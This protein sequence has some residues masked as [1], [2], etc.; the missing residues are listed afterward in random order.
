LCA[1]RGELG[2]IAAPELATHETLAAV[3]ERELRSS[4]AA[5]GIS[6]LHFLDLPDA[7]VDWAA[8]DAGTARALVGFIRQLKPRAIITFGPDGL[9]GHFDHVAIGSLTTEARTVAA[10]PF[11]FPDQGASFAGCRLFYPVISGAAVASL[12]DGA[13]R[14]G[15]PSSLWTLGPEHFAVSP[16][17]ITASVDVSTVLERKLAALHCHRTQLEADNVLLYL[18]AELARSFF[19]TEHFRCADGLPGGPL[20]SFGVG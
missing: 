18:T 17:A 5:L 12:I 6:D 8:A 13:K 19:G 11:A 20:E 10:D 16:D 3:R 15:I 2:P 14:A 7:G 9:Y 4:C 1:T